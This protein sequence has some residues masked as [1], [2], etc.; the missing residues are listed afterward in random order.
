MKKREL[1]KKNNYKDYSILDERYKQLVEAGISY[2]EENK[3]K[4]EEEKCDAVLLLIGPAKYKQVLRI[5]EESGDDF[6]NFGEML[7]V[8]E[9]MEAKRK[10][11]KKLLKKIT[12]LEVNHAG[13]K[14]EEEETE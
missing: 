14:T 3:P 10:K 5:M 11:T 1:P 12:A 4:T 8:A 7:R 13:I 2:S 9:E 6:I